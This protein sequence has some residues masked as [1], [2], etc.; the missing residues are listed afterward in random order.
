MNY[1]GP[2]KYIQKFTSVFA[3]ETSAQ[4]AVCESCSTK[5][6]SRMVWPTVGFPPHTHGSTTMGEFSVSNVGITDWSRIWAG[7]RSAGGKAASVELQTTALTKRS[8]PDGAVGALLGGCKLQQ[9]EVISDK[10]RA[11][12]KSEEHDLLVHELSLLFT[13]GR[14]TCSE[15]QFQSQCHYTA[16]RTAVRVALGTH[17]AMELEGGGTP[18]GAGDSAATWASQHS[19]L[20]S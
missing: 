15:G 6:I 1:E 18:D 11:E 17:G 10:S 7:W 14:R 13:W 9:Q 12:A 16:I 8:D 2:S 3:S 5:L 20:D 19:L 4:P